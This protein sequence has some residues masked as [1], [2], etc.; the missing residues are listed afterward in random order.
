MRP[1]AAAALAALATALLSGPAARAAVS[2]RFTP[3]MDA[4][5]AEV[6]TRNDALGTPTD[7][8][9]KKLKAAFTKVLA[10]LAGPTT[11]LGEDAASASKALKSLEKALPLDAT[12]K[13]L[14]DTAV[15]F[16]FGDTED[17][18]ADLRTQVSLKSNTKAR[19]KALGAL[20]D[21][22]AGLAKAAD[23]ASNSAALKGLAK[24]LKKGVSVQ[25]YLDDNV[26]DHGACEGRL[27]GA[28][29]NLL[30][31]VN[32]L[33]WI[34]QTVDPVVTNPGPSQS[35]SMAFWVCDAVNAS[36][37]KVS[38]TG[39]PPFGIHN[40]VDPDGAVGPDDFTMERGFGAIGSP[41]TVQDLTG[42]ID[43][44]LSDSGSGTY[45]GV[46]N[47]SN[48]VTTFIGSFHAEGIQ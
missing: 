18:L 35:V 19:A 28:G 42:T 5:A 25:K 36:W 6:N 23:A 48:G 1:F 45:A 11:T 13:N 39:V 33:P 46:F 34:A 47:V 7:Q 31:N 17:I 38:F 15:P 37:F 21:A 29:E 44:N 20:D 4:I 3:Y 12:M 24:A 8:D 9:G 32:T 2:N 26:D 22:D 43:L 27:L 10:E 30:T 41:P 16:Y 40:V 14:A